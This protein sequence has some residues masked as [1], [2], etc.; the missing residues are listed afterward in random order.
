[1][2]DKKS[3][4]L[5]LALDAYSPAEITQRV[6]T[7]GVA[8]AHLT[9]LQTLTLSG[10]AGAFIALGA[11]LYL[12][13]MVG[14]DP[15]IGMHRILG[16]IAFS[17]GLVLVVIAGAELFTGNNLIVIA[18]ADRL[19]T[20]RALLRNWALV[21]CGN[22]IGATIMV[23]L[24]SLA[25]VGNLAQGKLTQTAIAVAGAKTDLP[26]FQAFVSGILCNILVCLAV[27]M[28]FSAR[29]AS[30]KVLCIVFPIAAF[31]ALGFEHS[32]AN[33]FLIPF[34][35]LLHYQDGGPPPDLLA[36][37]AN[38]LPVTLGNIVGGGGLVAAV[39]WLIYHQRAR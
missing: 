20:T 19:I 33:M 15:G 30:G 10:L 8:K 6:E 27:W 22:F 3:S 36:L 16:G 14:S 13:A 29:R 34:G 26:F 28:C 32:I 1:M 2:A 23:A 12:L 21:Y 18:W 25:G 9:T 37:A 17:L 5:S 38:L 39:Y 35:M 4:S 7:A 31:V 11:T 24:V